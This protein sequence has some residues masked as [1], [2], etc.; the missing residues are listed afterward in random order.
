ML[1]SSTL[2]GFTTITQVDR[3]Q[4]TYLRNVC[5]VLRLCSIQSLNALACALFFGV[6]CHILQNVHVKC[7]TKRF[8]FSFWFFFVAHYFVERAKKTFYYNNWLIYGNDVNYFLN[9][10]HKI[11]FPLVDFTMFMSFMNDFLF[12]LINR[13]VEELT[14][15]SKERRLVEL[16][17]P[18]LGGGRDQ[19]SSIGDFLSPD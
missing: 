6:L 7:G 14:S 9:W 12:V 8:N 15:E 19:V 13:F 3:N 2:Y 1:K 10:V 4:R 17:L 16:M 11:V 18:F 5:D